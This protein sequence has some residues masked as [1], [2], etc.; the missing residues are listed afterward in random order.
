MHTHINTHIL[1]C[2]GRCQ[3]APLMPLLPSGPAASWHLSPWR[4]LIGSSVL[5][6]GERHTEREKPSFH[7]FIC[8][9]QQWPSPLFFCPPHPP[10]SPLPCLLSPHQYHA[11]SSKLLKMKEKK[12]DTSTVSN[13]AE[14]VTHALEHKI[15]R[16]P[17]HW[18]QSKSEEAYLNTSFMMVSCSGSRRKFSPFFCLINLLSLWWMS[19]LLKWENRPVPELT[20]CFCCDHS[21]SMGA[22]EHK[23]FYQNL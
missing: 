20:L 12:S 18:P 17:S 11:F 7:P 3:A 15:L 13:L 2:T 10:W 5:A 22:R 6:S 23:H 19:A 14:N 9:L 8:F 4:R 16:R 21:G 1:K